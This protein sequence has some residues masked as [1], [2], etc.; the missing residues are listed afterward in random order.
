MTDVE[1]MY[2]DTFIHKELVLLVCNKFATYLDKNELEEDAKSLRERAIIHD[3]SK[4]LNPSEFQALTGIINDKSCLKDAS[5]K[6]SSFKQD[7]IE[8]HWKHNSHHPEYF[9]NVE[10]MTRLDR[11][12]MVCDWCARAIQYNTNLLEFVE[13]RQSDRFHFPEL[14]FDEIYHYCKIILDLMN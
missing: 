3:N 4:I 12:E 11:I 6:L 5:S 13:K 9:D 14:M 7:A 10:D 8:L 1:K 2:Q